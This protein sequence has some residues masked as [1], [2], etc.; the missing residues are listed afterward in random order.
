[1]ECAAPLTDRRGRSRS[2]H[3]GSD[4]PSEEWSQDGFELGRADFTESHKGA[5]VMCV[6]QQWMEPGFAGSYGQSRT[7][8]RMGNAGF[9]IVDPRLFGFEGC[10][11]MKFW[12]AEDDRSEELAL[13][14]AAAPIQQLEFVRRSRNAKRRR[15]S[16]NPPTGPDR[17]RTTVGCSTPGRTGSRRRD[18]ARVGKRTQETILRRLRSSG[19]PA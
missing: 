10:D 5:D 3:N 18:R 14:L 2:R 16:G 15:P 17:G 4:H 11:R 19:P 6:V 7:A 8:T 13:Q 1:M 9:K 12:S